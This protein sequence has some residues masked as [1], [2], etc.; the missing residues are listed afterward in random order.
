[1]RPHVERL[2]TDNDLEE[3]LTAPLK[4]ESDV[5]AH[6]T[7]RRRP[8]VRIDRYLFPRITTIGSLQEERS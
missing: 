2:F 8:Y 5:I 7:N 6:K 4:P 1:M 3:R